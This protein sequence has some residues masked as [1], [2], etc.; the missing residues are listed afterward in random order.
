MIC[1]HCKKEVKKPIVKM[2][3][4]LYAHCRYVLPNAV[5]G[6]THPGNPLHVMHVYR[7]TCLAAKKKYGSTRALI[8]GML[9]VREYL[10]AKRI[11]LGGG[12]G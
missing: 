3:G 12:V 10:A 6:Y 4:R 2:S 11:V 9:Y 5:T 1:P 8:H 7:K